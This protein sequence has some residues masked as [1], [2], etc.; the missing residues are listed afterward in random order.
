MR[1]EVLLSTQWNYRNIKEENYL[2]G[3]NTKQVWA[4]Q[5]THGGIRDEAVSS[6]TL[7]ISRQACKGTFV[8]YTSVLHMEHKPCS[9]FACQDAFS[10]CVCLIILLQVFNLSLFSQPF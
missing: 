1:Q 5:Y 2:R 3:S 10:F 4:L 9:E 6:M 8:T 7:C